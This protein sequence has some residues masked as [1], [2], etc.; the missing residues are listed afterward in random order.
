[1]GS[2][3]GVA[4]ASDVGW[5][6]VPGGERPCA[7]G[8]RIVSLLAPRRIVE[9]VARFIVKRRRHSRLGTFNLDDDPAEAEDDRCEHRNDRVD[10]A[11]RDCSHRFWVRFVYWSLFS[12]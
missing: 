3:G 2:Q 9:P 1:M 12:P 4:L 7:S 10:P 11:I 8:A 5:R 6:R